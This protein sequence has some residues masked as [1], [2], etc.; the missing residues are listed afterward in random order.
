MRDPLIRSA[1][2]PR[3]SCEHAVAVIWISA[4]P[5]TI[6]LR[7]ESCEDSKCYSTSFGGHFQD[8]PSLKTL[9]TFYSSELYEHA[10]D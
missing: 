5:E 8:L 1:P 2:L 9:L 10:S 7:C 4:A 6:G 3:F